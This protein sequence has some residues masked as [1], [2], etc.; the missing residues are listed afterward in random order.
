MEQ[1]SRILQKDVSSYEEVLKKIEAYIGKT[2][3]ER[4]KIMS[5]LQ[6]EIIGFGVVTIVVLLLAYLTVKMEKRDQ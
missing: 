1:K 3:K 2:K 4:E 5:N 6:S